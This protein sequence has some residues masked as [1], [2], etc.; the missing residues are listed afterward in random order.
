[1]Q[2][3]GLGKE[4]KSLPSIPSFPMPV[5]VHLSLCQ[6]WLPSC[7]PHMTHGLSHLP[8][9]SWAV[10]HLVPGWE[11]L[12]RAQCHDAGVYVHQKAARSFFPS[13]KR[14]KHLT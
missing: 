10:P 3:G 2:W 1:M 4:F 5:L 8:P 9:S 7:L 13:M 12:T 6:A 11:W 14:Q